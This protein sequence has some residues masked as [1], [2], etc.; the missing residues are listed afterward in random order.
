MFQQIEDCRLCY[1][2]N[3]SSI[4]DL[5]NLA[6]TGVFPKGEL[7]DVPAGP[8]ELV[9]CGKCGLV[10]LR[11]NYDLGLLYGDTYGYR[12]GLNRSM[13]KHLE[14]KVRSIE[15]LMPGLSA[16]DLVIDIGSNDGT[17]LGSYRNAALR[18][19][20]I[21]PTGAKFGKYYKEGIE[22]IPEFFSAAA[23]GRRVGSQK[24]K[25]ITSIAM[26]YDLERPLDF[27]QDI[28]RRLDDNGIWIFEQSYLPSMLATNSYDTICHEH[29]EYYTMSQI[30]FMAEQTGLKI[31]DVE[32]NDANGGSFSVVAAKRESSRVEAKE[33]IDRILAE[34]VTTGLRTDA[35]FVKFRRAMEAHRTELRKL[36][37]E[38]KSTGKSVLG[39][40][41][42]T[43]GNVLL[44]YCGIGRDLLPAIAEVN[45]DKFGSF[46]P[47]TDIPII[48]ECE[49]MARCPDY[50]LVLPWH[51]RVPIL[52]RE[53]K[54]LTAGGRFIFPL[55]VLENVS[56]VTEEVGDVS[57]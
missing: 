27:V 11:H 30:V 19:V 39:Y 23:I 45:E 52:E 9:R 3:L 33:R 25:V 35:P 10:Q 2:A 55:P 16:G 37:H 18:R 49:A 50:F 29:L 13:V 12:S 56:T 36:L 47:G 46:T 26:F 17:L 1:S 5:G 6:L 42:S 34:E 57:R 38:I 43:K 31:I 51:F 53:R 15:C 24:A 44:Q 32:F 28:V 14:S 4:L 41:A 54:F 22:L 48:S 40:G 8:L 20:G 21:D 7:R